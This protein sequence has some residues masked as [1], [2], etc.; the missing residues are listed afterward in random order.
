MTNIEVRVRGLYDGL[1]TTEKKVADYF[2]ENME[3]VFHLPIARL[4]ENSGVSQVAWVRFCKSIGFD[5]LKDMK[6]SLFAELNN[7]AAGSASTPAYEFMDIKNFST[8]PQICDNIRSSSIQAIEDTIRMLD[9]ETLGAVAGEIISSPCIRIFGQGASGL[10]AQDLFYKL[11]RIGKNVL[12]D[13]NAHIQL[14]YAANLAKSDIAF[15][16]SNSGQTEEILE[17]LLLAKERGCCCISLTRYGKNPLASGCRYSLYNS[18]PEAD[19]R[20]G[21]MS[22]RIAQLTVIDAL[23]TTVANQDYFHVES[24]LE[25]SYQACISHRRGK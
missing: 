17:L 10:V 13:P 15:F 24:K 6:K 3:K 9:P 11:V 18:S 2:L 21:A 7:A 14:T 20:S 19:K 23:F 5:G 4:A 25:R 22:S 1:S 12:Y 8:I 16:I